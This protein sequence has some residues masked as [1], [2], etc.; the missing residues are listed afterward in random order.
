M[1]STEIRDLA[2][3]FEEATSITFTLVA[4]PVV[5]LIVGVFIDKTLSTT[6]LFI[7]IGIIMGVP[8]GIWRAQK[9]G[10]RIKK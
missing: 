8:I 1:K 4:L 7:I 3:A 2:R 5:L 10:R 9:I 6:P